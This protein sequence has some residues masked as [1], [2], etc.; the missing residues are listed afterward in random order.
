VTH[1]NQIRPSIFYAPITQ[2]F[3]LLGEPK[4]TKSLVCSLLFA[5]LLLTFNLTLTDSEAQ[6]GSFQ[7]SVAGTAV[8]SVP[9]Q[10]DLKVTQ[11]PGGQL[12]Q[13]TG[14][15]VSPEDVVQVKQ[16]ENLIVSTSPD[17]T[18]NTVAVRNMQ[19]I[20]VDLIPLPSSAWSLQGL[21]PGVYTLNVNVALSTS[22]ILGTYET[23]LVILEP[24][25]Q[26]LPPT[27]IINQIT[28]RQPDGRCPGNLT[29][30]NGTCQSPPPRPGPS[31]GPCPNSTLVNGECPTPPPPPLPNTTIPLPNDTDSLPELVPSPL[32]QTEP[33]R[34]P[35][36]A[37]GNEICPPIT[38]P[39]DCPEGTTGTPPDCVPINCP[40]GQIG[41]PPNCE[42]VPENGNGGDGGDG[43]DGQPPEGGDG[44]NGGDGDGGN[45]GDGGNIDIPSLFG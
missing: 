15:I 31:P 24:G 42:P 17:L 35:L 25:Q 22:G 20:P 43:E 40:E 34:C 28:I 29:L 27:T 21:L 44:G 8:G 7:L 1:S 5:F 39:G 13:V 9:R 18:T 16:G 2:I 37:N 36:D 3:Q 33:I 10:I 30:I 14:F 32:N 19:G 23:I 41:T 26:P 11:L 6:T 12:S 45:G 38:P 4:I